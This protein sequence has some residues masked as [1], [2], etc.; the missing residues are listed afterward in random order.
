VCRPCGEARREGLGL[1]FWPLARLAQNEKRKCTGLHANTRAGFS[2]A[3]QPLNRRSRGGDLERK[4]SPH[5]LEHSL[6]RTLFFTRMLFFPAPMSKREENNE[7]RSSLSQ[8]WPFWRP[9]PGWW[10][11]MHKP[12]STQTSTHRTAGRPWRSSRGNGTPVPCRVTAAI[13]ASPTSISIAV[14][15]S[16]RLALP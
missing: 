6:L 5:R 10:R 13:C 8:A 9:P 11:R 2:L 3:N 15:A 7:T 4:F 16:K 12:M 1:P 14:T